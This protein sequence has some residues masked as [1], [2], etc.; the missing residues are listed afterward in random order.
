MP[1]AA[2]Y[3]NPFATRPTRHPLES[4]R[5]RHAEVFFVVLGLVAAVLQNGLHGVTSLIWWEMGLMSVLAMVFLTVSLVLR[6]RWSLAR[7]TFLRTRRAE[8]LTS[9]VWLAGAAAILLAGGPVRR[10]LEL[11]LSRPRAAVLWSECCLAFRAV[12]HIVRG[13]RKAT[14]GGG[15]PAMLLV[16]SFLMLIG[17]GTVLL[18]L[19]RAAAD[20]ATLDAPFTDRLRVAL[21]TAT[22]ATCVTGLTVVDT[23]GADPHWSRMGQVVILGLFQLGGLG[24]MTCGAFFAVAAGR[25]MPIRES[26]TMAEM[27]ESEQV[28]DV[29]RLVRAILLFT[30]GSE[31]LGAV[32]LSGLW[33]DLP[34]G[35]RVFYSVF[36]SVSAFCNAGFALTQNSFVGWGTRW[37]VW[38]VLAG[39]II[40]GGLGFSVLYNVSLIVRS[41]LRPLPRDPLYGLSRVRARLMLTSWLVL[42]TTA[43]LLGLGTLGYFLLE[44]SALAA[45]TPVADAQV[46]AAVER[47][48][49]LP[50]RGPGIGERAAEAWFQSVT[51]RTAGFNTVDHSR[52][53]PA[54]KLFA[55]GLMFIGAS[56]GSTGGGIKTTCFALTILGLLAILRGRPH[57]EIRGRTIPDINIKR[58]FAILS[59]A[60]AAVMTT[61]MLLVVFERRPERF[62]DHLFEATSAFGTVGVSS[63]GT[64]NLTSPSQ[65]AVIVTMFLGRVGPLTLLIALAGRVR[66]A[67]YEY[68]T[69]RVALG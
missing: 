29:R 61:T 26:A 45:R 36:H 10:M 56:P 6:F 55:V 2:R 27:L 9:A 33:A 1:P 59:L 48:G 66:E 31:L 12:I 51:F 11:D 57:A 40:L 21:F 3:P 32:L 64:G 7:A 46:E 34:L 16:V 65:Y 14:A 47:G 37:Q 54:T 30:F 24:I 43:A 19:P 41:R 63:I 8:I 5:L 60:L 44:S 42:V 39:L 22:S 38:G 25:S 17:L 67:R 52:L 20:P 68:P 49:S 4:R 69:G 15:N 35:E 28:G 62:L 18:M 23:G 50:A 53:Q 58:A 13:M